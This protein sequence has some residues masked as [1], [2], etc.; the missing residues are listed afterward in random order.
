[1]SALS[2]PR[3]ESTAP[4]VLAIDVGSGGTRV[5]VYDASGRE[6]ESRRTRIRHQLTSTSDGGSTIDA[7]QIV[8]EV[9]RGI[10]H[11]GPRLPGPISAI[12]I[13][14]F[15]S[16]LVPVDAEGNALGPC[17]TYADTRSG[18]QIAELSEQVNEQ[19]LHDLTGARLHSSYVAPRL[20]WMAQQQ[21]QI[22]AR[23]AQFMALGEYVSLKLTGQA[24][25]GT[26]AAAWGGML[27]R[28]TGRYVPELLS[29]TGVSVEALGTPRDPNHTVSLQGTELAAQLPQLADAV[30]VP[31]VGDGL[32]ANLGIGALGEDTWGIS[33]ATS[34]AIRV[35]LSSEVEKLPS[36]LWAY[37]VDQGR[38]LVGSAM[39]DAGRVLSFVTDTFRLPV[40]PADLG[41]DPLLTNAPTA[42]TP[43]VVPF[44]SGERGTKWRDDIRAAFSHVGAS[45]TPNDFLRGALEGVALSYRRIAEHM[46]QAGGDPGRIVLSGGMTSTIPGWLHILADALG[47]EINHVAISRSTMRG[48]AL[49][50]LEQ[51]GVTD[52]QQVPV[53]TTV[54]PRAQHEEYYAGRLEEFEALADSVS[55]SS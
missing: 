40:I 51:L 9:R 27:N 15:A 44:L 54:E 12:G 21:P 50:A 8:D 37:R 33:T 16:S 26:A 29:A 17:I 28:R 4:Y 24:T 13:D 31:V 43:L 5:A 10:L 6:V 11:L 34:G 30:W 36:G 32:S 22:F 49:L 53:L 2:V 42:H 48:T 1:M 3:R 55:P 46:R 20:L 39:S 14:T 23:T 52:F 38:T 19:E 25:L 7:D 45:T 18:G 47:E 41:D 35:L